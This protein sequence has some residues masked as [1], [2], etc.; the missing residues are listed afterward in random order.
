[1]YPSTICTSQSNLL[2]M[3][4]TAKPR[5]ATNGQ[6]LE[7]GNA[8]SGKVVKLLA[9]RGFS[10]DQ[11]KF[12]IE[13][14]G[15]TKIADLAQQLTEGIFE[16]APADATARYKKDL[17]TFFLKV[18]GLSLDLSEILFPHR[19]GCDHYMVRPAGLDADAIFAGFEKLNLPKSKYMSGSILAKKKYEQQRPAI[20]YPF[21]HTG[22][23]EPDA[24]HR[25]KSY[26]D[27]IAEGATY[28]TIDEYMLVH[29]FMWWKF[30]IHLDVKGWTRTSTLDSV[31]DVMGGG[32]FC[33]RFRLGC[34]YRGLRHS[35]FGPRSEVL[36]TFIGWFLFK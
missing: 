1:M 29:Q 4:D 2:V 32:W 20:M 24:D 19:E 15:K 5:P 18:Y 13:S 22:D 10:F 33:G 7:I 27:F 9:E 12:A 11:A 16:L 28:M 17:E 30:N 34:G 3:K 35:G 25:G 31:G 14:V 6:L 36:P 21:A 26:D 8:V 23:A